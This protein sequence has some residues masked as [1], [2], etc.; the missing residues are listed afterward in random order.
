MSSLCLSYILLCPTLNSLWDIW[1]GSVVSKETMNMGALFRG[2]GGNEKNYEPLPCCSLPLIR[3]SVCLALGW[4]SGHLESEELRLN[5][6]SV[7]WEN[8]LIT[9]GL[10]F[11]ICI[12]KQQSLAHNR[13]VRAKWALVC[14]C[15]LKPI[16]L[17]D[18]LV[19]AIMT[20]PTVLSLMEVMGPDLESQLCC[21]VSLGGQLT[22]W[23]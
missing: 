5:A 19:K 23:A 9:V 18:K 2:K 22:T 17:C 13:A 12:T 21:T 16:P 14:E 11:P 7:S 15:A 20:R 10:C 6:D 3:P 4:T 8:Y 1:E